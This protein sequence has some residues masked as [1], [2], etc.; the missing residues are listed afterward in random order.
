LEPMIP[1]YVVFGLGFA[2]T[3][4]SAELVVGTPLYAAY[5]LEGED[6]DDLTLEAGDLILAINGTAVST[7]DE[8]IAYATAHP[9]GGTV[10]L[11]VE[12]EGTQITIPYTAYSE[13]VL[14]AMGYDPFHVRVGITCTY[15]FDFFGSFRAAIV[16][17][18][19]ASIS[20]YKTLWVLLTS[21]QINLSDMSGVVGIYEIT[22]NAA[23][24][25][26]QTL[27]GWVGLLSVNLGLVN[28]LPI[29]ALDGGRISFLVYEAIAKKKPNQKFESILNTVMFFLLMGLMVFITFQDITRLFS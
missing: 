5:D 25:G 20:I 21:S 7:W 28:L 12:R 29:P 15:G 10:Q 17:L 22:A 27:L 16:S 2:S 24:E 11:L 26:L 14:D 3:P 13:Q 1:Q 18:G 23:S 8:I 4:N 6:A 9:E 19:N